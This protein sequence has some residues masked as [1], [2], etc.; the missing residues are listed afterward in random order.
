EIRQ[1]DAVQTAYL[2]G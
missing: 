2:G 1:N